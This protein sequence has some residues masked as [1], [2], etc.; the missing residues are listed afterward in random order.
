MEPDAHFKSIDSK[1]FKKVFISL[2]TIL[3]LLFYR[4]EGIVRI[5]P[6]GPPIGFHG[7]RDKAFLSHGIRDS[8]K[9]LM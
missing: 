4:D 6:K 8:Q 1:F 9:T 2:A 7:I 3:E 5:Q